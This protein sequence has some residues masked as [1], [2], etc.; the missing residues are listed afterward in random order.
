[1]RPHD[2]KVVV[3]A[4]ASRQLLLVLLVLGD[5]TAVLADISS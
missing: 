2:E 1:V 5:E 3:A 4:R